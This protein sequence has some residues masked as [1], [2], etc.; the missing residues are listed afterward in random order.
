[1]SVLEAWREGYRAFREHTD[2]V[3]LPVLAAA[4]AWAAAEFAV[5]ALISSTEPSAQAGLVAGVFCFFVLGQLFWAVVLHRGLAALGMPAPPRP[6]AVLG[7]ALLAGAALTLGIGLCILPGVVLA[8]LGQFTMTSVI[9][10]RLDPFT[11]F[12]RSVRLVLARPGPTLGFTALATLTLAAGLLL[13]VVGVFPAI[14]LVAL[15]QIRLQS[16]ETRVFLAVPERD[17]TREAAKS[18]VNE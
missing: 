18:R 1:M 6:L 12:G 14:V 10:D 15:G 2:A 9:A 11:A 17:V 13:C 7:T 4:V 3:L 16:G 8:V 5:Q